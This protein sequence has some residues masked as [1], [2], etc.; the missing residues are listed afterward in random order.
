MV[1]IVVVVGLEGRRTVTIRV[2]EG[3]VGWMSG[4]R[5]ERSMER[6]GERRPLEE[7]D[8]LEERE[9]G[10]VCIMQSAMCVYCVERLEGRE[11]SRERE[12][13]T[14]ERRGEDGRGDARLNEESRSRVE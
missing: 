8:W 1:S 2:F 12:E 14:E 5:S 11:G 7:E 3:G 9:M 4:G 13:E 6:F 10:G